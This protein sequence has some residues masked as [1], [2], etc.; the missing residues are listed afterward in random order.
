M[1]NTRVAAHRIPFREYNF[2]ATSTFQKN[3]ALQNLFDSIP[4]SPIEY[5]TPFHR[6][7]RQQKRNE[8]VRPGFEP[9]LLESKPRVI[10]N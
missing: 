6:C 3:K 2:D 5:C 10:T 8:K 1:E 7:R 9:R 4:T